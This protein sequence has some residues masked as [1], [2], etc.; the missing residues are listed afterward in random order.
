VLADPLDVGEDRPLAVWLRR[1]L[2]E[3]PVFEERPDVV[4]GVALSRAEVEKRAAVTH[5]S[6]LEAGLKTG[7]RTRAEA[8][9]IADEHGWLQGVCQGTGPTSSRTLSA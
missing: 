2:K 9:R 3:S 7:A 8:V 4:D 6:V 1:N 5:E